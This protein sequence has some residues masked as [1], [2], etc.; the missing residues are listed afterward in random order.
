MKDLKTVI[1][2]S[3]KDMVK[4]KSFIIS[5]FYILYTNHQLDK[6]VIIFLKKIK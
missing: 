5:T 4:R 3:I 2:F 6:S 1:A